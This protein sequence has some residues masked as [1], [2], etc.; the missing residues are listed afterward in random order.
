MTLES[1]SFYLWILLVLVVLLTPW[2]IARYRFKDTEVPEPTG[3]KFRCQF[4][5]R[6]FDPDPRMIC[7]GGLQPCIVKDGVIVPHDVIDLDFVREASDDELRAAGIEPDDREKLLRGEH[8]S[9]AFCICLE[10]QDKEFPEEEEGADDE[11]D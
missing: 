11:Q 5:G 9:T 8:V 3:A 1:V 4:C 2:A 7:D 6:E 10:C